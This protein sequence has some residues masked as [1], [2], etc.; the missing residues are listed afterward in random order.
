MTDE[1]DE[2]RS[3]VNSKEAKVGVST[4]AAVTGFVLSPLLVPAAPV[5]VVGA[6]VL[7]AYAGVLGV[8]HR[9]TK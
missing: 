7:S 4:L 2:N 1:K 3:F 9:V 6:V 8:I 5:A